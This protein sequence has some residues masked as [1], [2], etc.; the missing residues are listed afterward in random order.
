MNNKYI[1]K[2][3]GRK[4]E[5]LS[6]STTILGIVAAFMVIAVISQALE[7]L[8]NYYRQP[9]RNA[10]LKGDIDAIEQAISDGAKVN[11]TMNARTPLTLAFT[12]GTCREE[13]GP[14]SDYFRYRKIR[15]MVEILISNG[16]N[17]NM[18]DESG[19]IPLIVTMTTGFWHNPPEQ[20]TIQEYKKIVRILVTNG[21]DVNVSTENGETPL[22]WAL[23]DA[24]SFDNLDVIELLLKNGAK[25]NVRNDEGESP[26][27]L[28]KKQENEE[29][30]KLLLN[31]S[32]KQ[33]SIPG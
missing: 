24:R 31:Y 18:A 4:G 19:N 3:D 6:T 14:K 22:H 5:K 16:V 7:S 13:E 27:E 23:Y 17:V 8:V 15:E 9:L 28:A 20:D 29:I 11:N 26:L 32:T 1:E 2:S 33:D 10:I 12:Y 25:V 21:A 30:M